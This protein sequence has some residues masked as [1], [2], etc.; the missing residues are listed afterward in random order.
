MIIIYLVTFSNKMAKH[1]IIR[2][3]CNGSVIGHVKRNSPEEGL[4]IFNSF[5]TIIPLCL[6]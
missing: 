3:F 4:K 6:V 5:T 2:F 1:F